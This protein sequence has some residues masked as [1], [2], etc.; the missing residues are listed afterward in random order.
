MPITSEPASSTTF[1]QNSGH[2]SC[3]IDHTVLS[4]QKTGRTADPGGKPIERDA[5]GLWHVRGFREVRAVLRSTRVQQAGFGADLVERMPRSMTPPIL[6]Q[7]GEL[8]Q[9]QRKQ[10]ARFFTPRR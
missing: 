3:P 9:L 5:A 8:H 4:Q 7:E 1:E 10:I 2:D 6:H